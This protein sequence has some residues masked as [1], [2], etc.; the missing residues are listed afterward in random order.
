MW[1][2]KDLIK[3]TELKKYYN[4]L[5]PNFTSSTKVSSTL[6]IEL[7]NKL[8]IKTMKTNKSPGQIMIANNYDDKQSNSTLESRMGPQKWMPST[9]LLGGS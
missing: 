8:K 1:K 7:E 6:P 2:I 3:E 4:N 5:T 9:T